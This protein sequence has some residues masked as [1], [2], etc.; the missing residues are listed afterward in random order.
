[1]VLWESYLLMPLSCS[2]SPSLFLST[3]ILLSF[4][5]SLCCLL[6]IPQHFLS[7]YFCFLAVTTCLLQSWNNSA[8]DWHLCYTSP[9]TDFP[10]SLSP[11]KRQI[12]WKQIEMQEEILGVRSTLDW[13]K[14]RSNSTQLWEIEFMKSNVYSFIITWQTWRKKSVGLLPFYLLISWLIIFYFMSS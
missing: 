2:F 14:A 11:L 3:F 13:K 8:L 4:S 7:L 12:A 10:C 5:L 9:A 1:M 6:I